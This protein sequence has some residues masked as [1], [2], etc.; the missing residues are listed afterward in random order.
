MGSALSQ[1]LSLLLMRFVT[2]NITPE[3]YGFYNLIVTVANLVIPFATLQ[4]ADALFRFV[5]RAQSEE[6]KKSYFSIAFIVSAVSIALIMVG[7]FVV[8]AFFFEM[9][10]PLL[11][12]LYIVTQALMGIYQKMTRSLGKNKIFV[13]GSLLRTG[14]FLLLEI[15]LISTLDM[16]GEAL[17]ISNIAC[18]VIFL[19]YAELRIHALRYFGFRYLNGAVFKDMM[20]FSIPLIPNAAFWWM[21]SSV[22]SV[23]VT[24][25][26][27]M[28][29]N[30]IYTVSNKF[31]NVLSMVTSVL[32]TSWQDSAV[33]EYGSDSFK[34]FFTKTFNRFFKL[35]FSA[36]AVL[37]PFIAVVFPYLIAPTYYDAIPYTPFL[38]LASG[39]STLSGFMAQIFVGQGKTHNS[40][41][42]SIAGMV[43]NITVI[44]LLV[45]RVGLWAA[46]I[47]S[48][49]S[50]TVLFLARTFMVR[51]EF[52][53]GIE[54]FRFGIVLGMLATSIY[55]YLKASAVW[56]IIWFAVTV[57]LAIILNFEFVKDIVTLLFRKFFKKKNHNKDT[58]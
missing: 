30:G 36:I 46:V 54:F 22:N 23:I 8:D 7:V 55:L 25:R 20:K 16:G 3:E 58:I 4:I 35:I 12:G 50:D 21:T 47:G 49:A 27:G 2:G 15:L 13:L 51:K 40:L 39:T 43:V 26:L 9:P 42:T 6:E 18:V 57:I 29:I 17:F 19:I 41:I 10:Y 5:I 34:Q 44:I 1:F 45:D 37:I 56:N 33:A 24:S 32:N 38:L 14:I 31:S 48:L 11:V 52:A 53:K 28:D